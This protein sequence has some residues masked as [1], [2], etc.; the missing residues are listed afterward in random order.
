MS[1]RSDAASGGQVVP[2]ARPV[3]RP[4]WSEWREAIRVVAFPAHLKKTVGIGFGVGTVL[5]C[6][7]QLGV[8]IRGDATALVWVKMAITYLVPFA[9]SNSGILIASRRPGD[10]TDPG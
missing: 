1:G 5:F 2:A 3:G 4:T 9:N 8:V 7:N 10:R 6:V